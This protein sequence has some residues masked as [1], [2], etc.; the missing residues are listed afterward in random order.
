VT[1][2]PHLC[3]PEVARVAKDAPH[4]YVAIDTGRG[5]HV[6]PVL[7]AVTPD[8]LWFAVPRGT[9]KARMLAKRP[10]VGVMLRGESS[11]VV[12]AGTAAQLDPG[13]PKELVARLPELW[14]AQAGVPSY[15]VRNAGEL[16]AFARDAATASG[17]SSPT[18]LVLV[19]VRPRAIEI[20]PN[21]LEPR[22]A[23]GEPAADGHPYAGVPED[24][25]DLARSPG[26]VV[27]GWSTPD[28]PLAVPACWD[29]GKAQVHWPPP[30][31]AGADTAGP[32]CLCFD[33][34]DGRGP[35]AKSGLMLRGRGRVRGRGA[36]RSVALDPDRVTWWRGFETG[37]VPVRGAA[38]A[39]PA[40]A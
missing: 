12:I 16:L 11:S 26:P 22:P 7:F 4:A 33:V 27:L 39:R 19:S 15:G 30:A 34:V 5:P 10:Q 3:G 13:R 20:A 35:I 17:A 14:R 1:D 2:G 9:L 37:T 28:G 38:A 32:A 25:A 21:D 36:S 31:S 40:A 29:D 8:R 18:E 24:L 23:G 6:T